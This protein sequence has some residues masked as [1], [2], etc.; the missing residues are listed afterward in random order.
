MCVVALAGCTASRPDLQQL[1][2]LQTG[3]ARQPPVILIHGVLG[4]RLADEQGREVWPGSPRKMLAS[5]YR[6]LG[7]GFDPDTLEPFPDTLTV[8]GISD[9]E[10]GV[11]FYA[12]IMQVLEGAG[13]YSPGEP[14]APVNPGDKH[15]YVFAYD[16]RQ[17]NIETV[18][19]LHDFIEQIRR[20]Y[21]DPDLKVDVIAHSMGGLILRYYIRYGAVDLLNGNA[22]PVSNAGA[23]QVRRAVLLGTPNFGSASTVRTLDEGFRVGFGRVGPETVATWPVSYQLLPHALNDWIVTE[24]GKPLDRDIFDPTLWQRFQWSVFDPEV[25]ERVVERFT[26]PVAGREYLDNLQRYFAKHIERARRF[27]WSLT[28]PVPEPQVHYVVFGGDCNQ[29]PGRILVEEIRGES[30]A[31][32]RPDEVHNKVDGIDYEALMM[33]P[34]DGTV[35]KASL[36]ARQTIDPTIPRH[37]YSDFPLDYAFFLCES[38][39]RLTGNINFQDNLLHVL[40]TAERTD[41]E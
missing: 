32:L 21:S 38:H 33:E 31:R 17:D 20:D 12:K 19:K 37:R 10:L 8:T 15:Y 5:D 30:V 40:L 9:K 26:D 41:A 4:S 7:L 16:W 29:T 36:L 11:D 14:G 27:T 39:S 13:R 28:V 23:E 22:F 2:G 18:R 24:T 35:T 25:E 3:S 1:Y 6:H 34:G